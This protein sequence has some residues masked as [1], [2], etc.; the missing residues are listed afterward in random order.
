GHHD[1]PVARLKPG[2]P[3]RL[4]ASTPDQARWE[5]D[6][7]PGPHGRLDTARCPH[8][9]THHDANHV[10]PTCGDVTSQPNGQ[11]LPAPRIAGRVIPPYVIREWAYLNDIECPP[12]GPIPKQL[13]H[14]YLQAN[15]PA[16][17]QPS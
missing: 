17:R 8:C 10:C 13:L 1:A 16:Q 11:P 15:P 6:T 4:D 2:P 3:P 14:R 5:R 12:R 9:H 7:I